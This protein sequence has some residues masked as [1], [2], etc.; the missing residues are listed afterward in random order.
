[1]CMCVCGFEASFFAYLKYVSSMNDF[2]YV[3]MYMYGKIVISHKIS[4]YGIHKW[5]YGILCRRVHEE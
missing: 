2:I 4:F 3:K 1:M 5:K